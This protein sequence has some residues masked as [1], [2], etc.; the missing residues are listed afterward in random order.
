MALREIGIKW[1]EISG[2]SIDLRIYPGGIVGDEEEMIR[3][4]RIGQLNAAALSG[5]GINQISPSILTLYIP[6]MLRDDD[7]VEYILNEMSD[8]F[9]ENLADNG[10][11]V[12]SWIMGGW[13]YL[14]SKQP[15]VSPEDLMSQKLLIP[16][17]DQSLVQAWRETGFNVV[18]LSLADIMIVIS[19]FIFL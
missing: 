4:I 5:L 14:F 2:N 17:N 10:Y 15:V 7:E 1:A 11:T 3:K 6:F 8:D 19:V 16:P 13:I 12:I 18:E 9:K